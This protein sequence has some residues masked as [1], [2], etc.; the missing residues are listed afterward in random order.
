MLWN[1]PGLINWGFHVLICKMSTGGRGGGGD[2]EKI[3]P[4]RIV[5]RFKIYHV[6]YLQTAGQYFLKGDPPFK[7]LL[8]TCI[9]ILWN[10]YLKG[11]F[12][13]PALKT[14]RNKVWKEPHF[15]QFP[16]RFQGTA[17]GRLQASSV[18]YSECLSLSTRLPGW[19]MG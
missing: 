12:Q 5:T 1:S 11:R 3:A 8:N 2:A 14:L 17:K 7:N 15:P 4:H 19:G 9:R 13:G 16:G 18:F 10:T 6:K